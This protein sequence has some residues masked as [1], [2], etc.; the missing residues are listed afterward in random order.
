MRASTIT[1]CRARR[2][3]PDHHDRLA[4]AGHEQVEIRGGAFGEGRID[5]QLAVD[6]ADADTRVRT[7]PGC[8]RGARHRAPVIASVRRV[9]AI[10]DTTIAITCVS[11]R[12]PLGN[13]GRDGRS[14]SREV[15]TSTSVIRPSRLK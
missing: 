2:S 15:N 4:A 7:G 6:T 9:L 14:M 13:R 5:D 10:V 8:R 11:K 1:S 12:Q 3:R